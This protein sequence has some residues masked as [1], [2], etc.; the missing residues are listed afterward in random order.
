MT[1]ADS[2]YDTYSEYQHPASD[3]L[4]RRFQPPANIPRSHTAGSL[5]SPQ[6]SAPNSG[7]LSWKPN[8]NRTESNPFRTSTVPG[9][10]TPTMQ[11]FNQTAPLMEEEER[12]MKS[13]SK[14][15]FSDAS[16][17]LE[18]TGQD[19]SADPG[20]SIERLTSPEGEEEADVNECVRGRGV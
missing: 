9:P 1:A 5:P 2:G 7:G 11:T 8:V 17:E 15:G 4:N 12:T 20:N 16:S 19:V 13:G 14:S 6:T 10:H 18:Y 3:P